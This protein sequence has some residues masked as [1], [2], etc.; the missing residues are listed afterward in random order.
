MAAVGRDVK[1]VSYAPYTAY[2][3]ENLSHVIICSPGQ[4]AVKSLPYSVPADG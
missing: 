3:Q 1:S 4:P 2:A